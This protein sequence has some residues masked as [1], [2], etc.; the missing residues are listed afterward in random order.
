MDEFKN[1]L[2][3]YVWYDERKTRF[4]FLSKFSD[5]FT[6]LR[7]METLCNVDKPVKAEEGVDPAARVRLEQAGPLS[8]VGAVS[9]VGISV[10]LYVELRALQ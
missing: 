6:N 5:G 1:G 9:D 7:K 10:V 8:T 4:V 3:P 2:A